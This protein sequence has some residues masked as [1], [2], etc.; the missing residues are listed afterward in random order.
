MGIRCQTWAPHN[1]E[2]EDYYFLGYDYVFLLICTTQKLP[3]RELLCDYGHYS[4]H[5]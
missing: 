4:S 2:W 1:R 3:G 5:E